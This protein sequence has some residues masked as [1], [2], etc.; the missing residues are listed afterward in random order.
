MELFYG[1]LIGFFGCIGFCVILAFADACCDTS[2]N[3]EP[4]ETKYEMRGFEKSIRV[5][6]ITQ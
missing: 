2:R 3:Q 5:D 6:M 1:L 4:P